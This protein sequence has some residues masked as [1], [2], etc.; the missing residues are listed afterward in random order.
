MGLLGGPVWG[1]EGYLPR[2]ERRR[3]IPGKTSILLYSFLLLEEAPSPKN[4]TKEFGAMVKMMG[5]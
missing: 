1:G 3:Q 5:F 4:P 2:R